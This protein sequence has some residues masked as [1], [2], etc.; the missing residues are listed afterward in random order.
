MPST[1]LPAAAT[2]LPTRRRALA[3]LAG[4]GA[5]LNLPK[6]AHALPA[7]ADPI[8]AL[9]AERQRI[10]D[11]VDRCRSD[12]EAD[13]LMDR[14]AALDREAMANPATTLA[15]AVASLEWVKAEYMQF[16]VDVHEGDADQGDF[17]T[18]ALLDGALGVLR[19][20]GG[21]A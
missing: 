4:A 12:D 7:P 17:L 2:G 19:S 1:T 3:A 20:I 16:K 5:A 14:W 8:P 15:G 11:Q 10:T 21:E 6:A 18:L 13:P 9:Y